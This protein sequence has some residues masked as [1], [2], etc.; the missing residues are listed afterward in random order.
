MGAGCL[1]LMKL[2]N[3]AQRVIVDQPW[4]NSPE[5]GRYKH[6]ANSYSYH[7]GTSKPLGKGFKPKCMEDP[8][9]FFP[10]P[11][12]LDLRPVR[13][14]SGCPKRDACLQLALDAEEDQ[15]AA[16]RF[17][18]YGGVRPRERFVLAKKRRQRKEADDGSTETSL[19]EMPAPA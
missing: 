18:I 10:D 12:D 17:G 6:P 9:L 2:H 4:N 19:S 13:I 11:S 1:R 14:C 5:R 7:C 16:M 15:P 8:E 3:G